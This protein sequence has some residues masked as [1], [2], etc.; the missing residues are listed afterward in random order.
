LASGV[1][2]RVIEPGSGAKPTQASQ[3]QISYKGTV[4]NGREIVDTA[5]AAPNQPAGPVTIKVSEIPLA[6]LREALQ[7]M[8]NGA[9]WEVVIPGNAAYGTT[10]EA[11]ELVNQAVVFDVKLVSFK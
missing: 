9:R 2:Y 4:H 10:I 5:Q 11:G 3:V 1:Q 7:L 6:G 8:P